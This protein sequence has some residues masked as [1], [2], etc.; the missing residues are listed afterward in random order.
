MADTRGDGGEPGSTGHR[1][2]H[3]EPGAVSSGAPAS[4]T[5][6]AGRDLINAIQADLHDLRRRRRERR[7]RK[8]AGI[9]EQAEVGQ[10]PP[11]VRS[12][13][14]A[15]KIFLRALAGAGTMAVVAVVAIAGLIVWSVRNLPLDHPDAAREEPAIV[16]EAADGSPLGRIGTL[17]AADAKLSDIPQKLVDAVLSTEDRRF[18]SHFGVDPRGVLRALRQNMKAGGIVEGGSTITQQL[19][20]LRYLSSE[21]TYTRKLQEAVTAVWL[22]GRLSKDEILTEYL[23][24]VYLGANARGMPAAARIYFDK[25]LPE[26]TLAESAMLAGL[27]RAPSEL[28]PIRDLRAAR[29]RA[30]VVLDNMVENGVLE[31]EEAEQAQ[32]EPARLNR[33]PAASETGGWFANWAADES[34]RLAG[35][36]NGNL[37]VRTTLVPELQKLAETTVQKFLAGGASHHISQAAFIA[38]R[39]DGEVVAMVGGRDYRESQFNRATQALRQ[40]GSAFKLFVY[41]AALRAGYRPDDVIDA[42]PIEI[43]KWK[44]Q[45]FGG[46]QYGQV[47]L[48]DAFAKSINTAAARLA[49][50][51]GLKQVIAA[52]RD[53]GID[54][55]LPEHPSLALG[56]AEVSLIDLTGAYASVLFGKSPVE[57]Y[58]VAAFGREEESRLYSVAPSERKPLGPERAELIALLQRVVQQGTGHQAALDGFAAGKTGTSENH[59]DAWFIGFTENLVAGVWVGNDDG[60]PMDEVTGGSLP[61]QMWQ[62]FMTG[63]K[64]LVG[65]QGQLVASI[66]HGQPVAASDAQSH[67]NWVFARADGDEP[68]AICDITACSAKYRSFRAEDCSYQPFFGER[69]FCEIGQAPGSDMVLTEPLV[70]GP[71]DSAADLADAIDAIN[72]EPLTPPPDAIIEPPAQSEPEAVVEAAPEQTGSIEPLPEDSAPIVEANAPASGACDIAACA[73][74]YRSFN[75][76]DCTYQPFGDGPRQLCEIG[77]G[78]AV[79]LAPDVEG[80]EP[81]PE[82]EA[83]LRDQLQNADGGGGPLRH[84]NAML[85]NQEAPA[86]GAAPKI[87]GIDAQTGE[88]IVLFDPAAAEVV[89]ANACNVAACAAE[90]SSFRAEDCTYQPLDGGPRLYCER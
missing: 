73:A 43:D 14:R 72:A 68:P 17:K 16:L 77:A 62:S 59:R 7:E 78:D 45:N 18:Y 48:A 36:F 2:D 82:A 42:G 80:G 24:N 88:P 3:E 66:D 10:E 38:M 75:A 15:S 74:K 22:E 35:P 40:P 51:V 53:L 1:G 5:T 41:L 39:P 27:I 54:A 63:A 50:D 44:P 81:P 86:D 8:Q 34:S 49:Q 12:R 55:P 28:N 67:A 26:L 70:S 76:G 83:L 56:A 11:P 13:S 32:A 84:L 89:P 79:S 47:T 60:A 20:R 4:R 19:V 33:P 31:K 87:V 29:E 71:N 61:A 9:Q 23:N 21:R 37:K 25:D 85:G 69:R 46:E 65:E 57:P 52:A 6:A 64:P 58:G 30:S 90:Y